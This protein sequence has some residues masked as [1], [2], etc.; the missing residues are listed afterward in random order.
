MSNNLR[1][2]PMYIQSGN[3]E[4]ENINIAGGATDPYP[5]TLGSEITVNTLTGATGKQPGRTYKRIQVDS[6]ATVAPFPGAVA[7]WSNKVTSLVTTSPTTLGRG[8]VAGIFRN[9]IGLGNIGFIQRAGPSQVFFVDTPTAVPTA[10]GLLVIPSAT[11]GKA[12]CL[13]AGS[14]ATYPPIG[15]TSGGMIGG[16]GLAPVDLDV[17]ETP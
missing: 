4:A 3:L 15:V 6:A 14:A 17:P 11:A 16:T 7:W 1:N 8:R 2:Q 5:G 13:A 10:A 12:D 9:A